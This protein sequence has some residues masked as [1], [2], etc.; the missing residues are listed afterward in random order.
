MTDNKSTNKKPSQ[1]QLPA[2]DPAAKKNAAILEHLEQ[3]VADIEQI[4]EQPQTPSRKNYLKGV[5]FYWL[6]VLF[7]D[8]SVDSGNLKTALDAS[9]SLTERLKSSNDI[10]KKQAK[11]HL[12]ENLDEEV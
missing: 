9:I 6:G 11:K 2:T 3:V 10:L 1:S 8:G 5:L 4:L 12:E 7:E